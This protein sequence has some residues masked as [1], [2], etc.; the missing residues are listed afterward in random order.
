MSCGDF[1]AATLIWFCRLVPQVIGGF[2][3]T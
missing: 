1:D 3:A 2:L